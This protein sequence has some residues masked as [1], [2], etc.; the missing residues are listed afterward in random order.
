MTALEYTDHVEALAR[1]IRAEVLYNREPFYEA[2]LPPLRTAWVAPIRDYG[3]ICDPDGNG[4]W[5]Y[6]AQGA[7]FA[8]LHELGHIAHQHRGKAE[9]HRLLD[10]EAEAWQWAIDHAAEPMSAASAEQA[11]IS[12]EAYYRHYPEG[13]EF[14][15]ATYHD[16]CDVL[17]EWAS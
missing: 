5:D 1:T 16:L 7:Y 2:A 3:P 12:L 14:A 13:R 10:T 4:P 8:A 15:T 6:D 17:R 11:L 9:M